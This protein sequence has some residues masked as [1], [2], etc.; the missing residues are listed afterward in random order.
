[1][2]DNTPLR[3][4]AIRL[5]AEGRSRREIGELLGLRHD[6]A[7]GRLLVGTEP[8]PE[9]RRARA[10]DA[11]RD[12][13]RG[14]RARGWTYQQIA[15]ELGVS[16]SSCSLWLRDL[17]HP[18]FERHRAGDRWHA[19][20]APVLRRRAATRQ[21]AKLDAANEML[22][23]SRRDIILAGAVAYWCEGAKAKAWRSGERVSFVNSD[24]HLITVFLRFLD[25]VG[26]EPE[27]RTF[28]LSIHETADVDAAQ[29]YWADV[30]G[31]SRDRFAPTT[32]KRHSPRTNR[33]NSGEGYHG[34]LVIGVQQSAMLYRQIEGWA[35]SL[36]LG[37]LPSQ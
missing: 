27:R 6:S 33:I 25:A 10:K 7:V 36:A 37:R 17:P 18:V 19:S 15:D 4:Q 1:M 34:C 32:I 24:R 30:V 5:R 9:L 2:T 31:I 13:A 23:L 20:W 3:A 35:K 16:T 21:Q 14:L 12:R 26:V 29:Q 11:E 22:P 28:R 8:P